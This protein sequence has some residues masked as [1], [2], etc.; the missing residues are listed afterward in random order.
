MKILKFP[1]Y[2]KQKSGKT[3]V[4]QK[5]WPNSLLL[6][7]NHGFQQPTHRC[8]LKNQ[9]DLKP[10]SSFSADKNA[11]FKFVI[12]Y[13]LAS[14]YQDVSNQA[15]LVEIKNVTNWVKSLYLYLYNSSINACL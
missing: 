1:N 14:N 7:T 2:I 3:S 10:L 9:K 12:S 5:M 13:K 4:W 11:L 8:S 6:Q 15:G